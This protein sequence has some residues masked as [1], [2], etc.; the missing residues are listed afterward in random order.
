MIV[1][2]LGL[3]GAKPLTTP[4]VDEVVGDEPSPELDD[5]MATQYRALVA[6]C[7]YI[8]VGRADAQ[9]CVKELCRDMSV[10]TQASWARLQRLGRYFL[11][12]PRAVIFLAHR[13]PLSILN[14]NQTLRTLTSLLTQTGQVARLP[15]SRPAVVLLWS[16]GVA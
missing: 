2:E 8:A 5:S 15:E 10:P 16:A 1:E 7:N 3:L 4:G 9:Y 11:G 6:R 12:P 14:G 13:G